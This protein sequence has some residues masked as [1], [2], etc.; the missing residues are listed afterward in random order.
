MKKLSI[1][2]LG[3]CALAA[4]GC[5][6]DD[7]NKA[8]KE[9]KCFET[10]RVEMESG[11]DTVSIKSVKNGWQL[12]GVVVDGV[13]FKINADDSRKENSFV[14]LKVKCSDKDITLITTDN[15]D[16]VRNFKLQLMNNNGRMEEINGTQND[17]D[18]EI[19]GLW[20]DIIKMSMHEVIA[21]AAGGEISFTTDAD[22]RWS[23]NAIYAGCEENGEYVYKTNTS[24]KE[25][26]EYSYH[27][28][29]EK[30]VGWIKVKRN[31]NRVF[32]TLEPN[33]TGK[34]REFSISLVAGDY[35]GWL[36]GMQAAE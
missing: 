9:S 28:N 16:N 23:F 17:N 21:A 3:M 26:L 18:E 19:D 15:H 1:L 20:S 34:K 10:T 4:V 35:Q 11:A 36:H 29:F 27:K 30:T 2:L 13:N 31:D 22:T 24:D 7:D 25:E 12:A 5:S 33:T 32:I 8:E 14:W 6:S